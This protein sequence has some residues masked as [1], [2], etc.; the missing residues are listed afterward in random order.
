MV[1]PTLLPIAPNGEIEPTGK[2]SIG[3]F[4][5]RVVPVAAARGALAEE[6][7]G[8]AKVKDFTARIGPSGRIASNPAHDLSVRSAGNGRIGPAQRI[9]LS[10][11]IDRNRS[12]NFPP[13]KQGIAPPASGKIVLL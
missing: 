9:D 3:L 12:E 13:V 6:P 2:M 11:R 4:G 8:P 5:I 1:A 10:V 7:I